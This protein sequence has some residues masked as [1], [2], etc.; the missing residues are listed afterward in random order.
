MKKQKL[1]D[2]SLEELEKK[3]KN[4]KLVA[5]ILISTIVVLIALSVFSIIELESSYIFVFPAVF[6]PNLM[7]NFIMIKKIKT[8]IESR[9]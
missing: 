3:H 6:V 1:I 9:K 5:G 4:L 8:E 2:L 7:I